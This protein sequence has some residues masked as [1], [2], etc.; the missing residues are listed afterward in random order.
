MITMGEPTPGMVSEAEKAGM[1]S[2]GDI[3]IPR[4]QI[5]PIRRLLEGRF[6][7]PRVVGIRGLAGEVRGLYAGL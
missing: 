5:L 6:R 1:L 7:L 2:D 4:I 3:Q